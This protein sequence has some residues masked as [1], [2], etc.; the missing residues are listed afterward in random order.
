VA[1]LSQGG[2][3]NQFEDAFAKLKAELGDRADAG[4]FR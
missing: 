4:G 1:H 2:Q 3:A